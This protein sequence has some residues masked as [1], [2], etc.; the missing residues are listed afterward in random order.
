[1]K[2]FSFLVKIIRIYDILIAFTIL[3]IFAPIFIFVFIVCLIESK[4]HFC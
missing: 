1:M 4:G 2:K 3:I